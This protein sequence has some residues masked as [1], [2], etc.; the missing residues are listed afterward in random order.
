MERS[1]STRAGYFSSVCVCS[2]G[3]MLRAAGWR[4]THWR[5]ASSRSTA[6]G[7]RR[8]VRESQYTPQLSVP[9]I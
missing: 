5:S 3:W 8:C 6:S 4:G 7:W 2:A 9:H 1:A